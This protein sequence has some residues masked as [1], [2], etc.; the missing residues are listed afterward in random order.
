MVT[1]LLADDTEIM[2]RM[3]RRLLSTENQIVIVGEAANFT[4]A[5][6]LCVELKPDVVILDLH[7]PDREKM[8]SLANL[9][10]S[11]ATCASRIIAISLFQ[12]AETRIA[13]RVLDVPLL[14]K[15]NLALE[16][17]PAILR[18]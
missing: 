9:K 8:L 3:I 11:L 18:E 7:M 4:E 1:V 10:A 14:E 17:I 12:D 13:S 16:L 5:I 2:R 6:A 15:M